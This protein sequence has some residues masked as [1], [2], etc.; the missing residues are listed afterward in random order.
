MTRYGLPFDQA[1]RMQKF[2]HEIMG[3]V[4][5]LNGA[6]ISTRL[7]AVIPFLFR[8]FPRIPWAHQGLN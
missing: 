8:V 6:L 1:V 2:A 4:S 3:E 7:P 5:A